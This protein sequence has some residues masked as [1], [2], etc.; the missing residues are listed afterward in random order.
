MYYVFGGDHVAGNGMARITQA[1]DRQRTCRRSDDGK[2][3]V[4]QV[5]K[6]FRR[7]GQGRYA[8]LVFNFHLFHNNVFF[9][10]D[11]FLSHGADGF[12]AAPAMCLTC[13]AI[14]IESVLGGPGTPHALHGWRGIHQHAI[15]I[16]KNCLGEE[17]HFPE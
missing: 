3:V 7:A 15:H 8:F 10:C 4:G 1:R 16:K 6:Q 11:Q 12:N 14:R 9:F 13:D 17:D 5:G 2:S